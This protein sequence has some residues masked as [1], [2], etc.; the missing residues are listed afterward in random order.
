MKTSGLILAISCALA[1]CVST[2]DPMAEPPTQILQSSRSADDID[3]CLSNAYAAV[4]SVVRQKRDDGTIRIVL[5]NSS[6]GWVRFA[7]N[8]IPIKDGTRV[9]FWKGQDGIRWVS[10]CL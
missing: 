3:Y 5:R 4:H 7:V 10:G 6:T 9:E 2:S 1:G 8:L